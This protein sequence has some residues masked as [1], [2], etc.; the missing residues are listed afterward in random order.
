MYKVNRNLPV[1]LRL[2]LSNKYIKNIGNEK[3]FNIALRENK[4]NFKC[5]QCRILCTDCYY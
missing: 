2:I 4:N 3:K 5:T 1:K